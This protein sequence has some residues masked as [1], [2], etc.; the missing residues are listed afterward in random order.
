MGEFTYMGH[1]TPTIHVLWVNHG[2][3]FGSEA[4]IEV[5]I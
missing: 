1:G 3:L 5:D 2:E 4:A